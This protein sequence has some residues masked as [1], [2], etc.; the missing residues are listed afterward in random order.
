MDRSQFLR[1]REGKKSKDGINMTGK[2]KVR[3]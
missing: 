3:G 1:G 2:P